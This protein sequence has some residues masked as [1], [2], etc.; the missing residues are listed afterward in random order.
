MDDK[1]RAALEAYANERNWLYGGRFDRLSGI[2]DGISTA[3][4]CLVSSPNPTAGGGVREALEKIN[5]QAH[6][7]AMLGGQSAYEACLAIEGLV[8]QLSAALASAPLSQ[9]AGEP[10]AWS[11]KCKADFANLW[12]DDCGHHPSKCKFRPAPLPSG[13]DAVD[14]ATVEAVADAIDLARYEH[15]RHPRERPRSFEE[16]DM[17]DREYAERLARAAIRA[18]SQVQKENK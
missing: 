10:V 8:A 3:Q 18:L 14:P 5:G 2:F 7:G 16:A 17:S 1:E 15:P 12:C 11:K 13:R 6:A 9:V 4:E